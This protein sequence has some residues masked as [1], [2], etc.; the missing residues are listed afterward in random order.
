MIAPYTK[1]YTIKKGLPISPGDLVCAV[2]GEDESNA[3]LATTA[4]LAG[5]SRLPGAGQP[6]GIVVSVKPNDP[7]NTTADVTVNG[8]V[9][10]SITG[11]GSGP[12]GVVR[13]NATTTTSRCDRAGTSTNAQ[14]LSRPDALDFA[15]GYCD[16][17][18]EVTVDMTAQGTTATIV[19][20]PPS[21]TFAERIDNA[22]AINNWFAAHVATGGKLR[23][24][25]PTLKTPLD[26]SALLTGGGRFL[27]QIEGIL[28][29][30]VNCAEID[31]PGGV[32]LVGAGGATGE[33]SGNFRI[34]ANISGFNSDGNQAAE[35]LL[36]GQSAALK[37]PWYIVDFLGLEE[38]FTDA[39]NS[40]QLQITSPGAE[41]YYII[42]TSIPA[43]PDYKNGVRT[44]FIGPNPAPAP[45]TSP[46]PPLSNQAGLEWNIFD[47]TGMDKRHGVAASIP[48]RGVIAVTRVTN[49]SKDT[50]DNL[51]L[52]TAWKRFISVSNAE[53]QWLNGTFRIV[54][55]DNIAISPQTVLY[56]MQNIAFNTN[57]YHPTPA[58]L[59]DYGKGGSQSTPTINYQIISAL[60]R[61]EGNTTNLRDIVFPGVQGIGVLLDGFKRVTGGIQMEG[62]SYAC[63]TLP[64]PIPL[65]LWNAFEVYVRD[66][67]MTCSG[68]T[69]VLLTG[70]GGFLP[71]SGLLY[72]EDCQF[73]NGS[74]LMQA[75]GLGYPQG[76]LRLINTQT[77]DLPNSLIQL[78][79]RG[80]GCGEI[81]V[82]FITL[83]DA[84]Q[85]ATA[86][87]GAVMD[88][89]I[90]GQVNDIGVLRI[91][92]G[93]V[94]APVGPNVQ[95]VRHLEHRCENSG[96]M[97]S[98]YSLGSLA[99]YVVERSN[100]LDVQLIGSSASWTPTIEF[101]F[102]LPIPPLS[103]TNWRG[104]APVSFPPG[105]RGPDGIPNPPSGG[106]NTGLPGLN[107]VLTSTSGLQFRSYDFPLIT[108]QAGDYFMLG[109]WVQAQ[110]TTESAISQSTLGF[111]N[112]F[113]TRLRVYGGP[114]SISI[115]D[116]AC[117]LIGGQ[118]SYVTAIGKVTGAPPNQS[119][120]LVLTLQLKDTALAFRGIWVKYIPVSANIP[121]REIIRWYRHGSRYQVPGT[122][123]GN[124]GIDPH[125]SFDW[126]GR[127]TLGAPAQGLLATN[128][129]AFLLGG[130][131]AVRTGNAAPNE[132]V[133]GSPGDIYMY[134]GG[135]S[136]K[137]LWVK[138]TGTGNTG[139]VAK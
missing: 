26:F 92:G 93:S 73:V 62:V 119:N 76:Q 18:G 104:S 84:P 55:A 8:P 70:D 116:A 125:Q 121:E 68:P 7:D 24:V 6:L 60:V 11:L 89:V 131:V 20:D 41:G 45:E 15:V 53:Q 91:H 74:I 85:G 69:N 106:I 107:A 101:G 99:D 110:T 115:N 31:L 57:P 126:G 28:S 139:W 71:G 87:A 105:L 34:C 86:A 108:P 122:A 16:T 3:Q 100:R 95:A 117:A 27:I 75:Q 78:D 59:P 32:S 35:R 22:P 17:S 138:E 42:L 36:S 134:T 30:L 9:P 135:G 137:T 47:K 29:L 52:P 111:A 39:D 127:A 14:A 118:W 66:S 129:P 136:G 2:P 49:L 48:Q 65:V 4:A 120:N 46:V 37:G 130:G 10:A 88:E 67:S 83:S 77:E 98:S 80:G 64:Y 50:A 58:T 1:T 113:D 54:G 44:L 90:P 128:A 132:H 63:Q 33:A 103:E 5:T 51:K 81:N 56:I 114:P 94:T 109:M 25:N 133:A 124:L 102:G 61:V 19:G 96:E 40:K 38:P 13:V 112:P 79:P 12:A 23:L 123:Q 72:F 43:G 21:V 82:D 97:G